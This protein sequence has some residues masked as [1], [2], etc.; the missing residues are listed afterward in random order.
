MISEKVSVIIPAYNGEDFLGE[1][2]QS[3]LDQTYQNFE[4]VIVDDVSTDRT[5]QIV[6]HFD[7]SRIRY[8]L[9]P[10]N[11]GANI[12][13]NT[14]IRSSDG[15]I[16]AF[17]D[18]DDIFHSEKLNMHVTLLHENPE[19]GFTYNNRFNFMH[20]STDIRDMWLPPSNLT[21]AD[22]V[23]GFPLSPSDMV[24]R[25]EWVT[26]EDRGTKKKISMVEK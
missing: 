9:H 17:L 12:A 25:R 16:I 2:I 18:Q 4:I 20:S 1:A 23:L 7:D 10:K 22:L 11:Q 15:E 24:I 26:Q 21:L 3:V 5:S 13:R 19:I 8:I 6:Q 14:G